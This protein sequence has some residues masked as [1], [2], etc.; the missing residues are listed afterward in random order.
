MNCFMVLNHELHGITSYNPAL[1]ELRLR[2]P[3]SELS[4]YINISQKPQYWGKK[5]RDKYIYVIGSYFAKSGK[6]RLLLCVA[7]YIR[8]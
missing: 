1:S 7:K 6:M 3:I 4:R 2:L 5:T 8:M